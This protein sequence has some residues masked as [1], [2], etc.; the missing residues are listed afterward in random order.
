M[1]VWEEDE[2]NHLDVLE[3]EKLVAS[4]KINGFAHAIDKQGRLYLVEEEEYPRVV[5][6]SVEF[7]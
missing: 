2:L 5:R 6:V 3:S 4:Q 7:K 1:L